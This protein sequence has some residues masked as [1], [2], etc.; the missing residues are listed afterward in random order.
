MPGTS[1]LTR[2][3]P[4]QRRSNASSF[5]AGRFV[6]AMRTRDADAWADF[7]APD[8]EWLEYRHH[9][10][11]RD[12][13][14]RE[15]NVSIH[16]FLKSVCADNRYLHVEDLVAGEESVWFR[17]MV[18]RDDDRMMIEHVH[19]RIENGLIAREIDVE[20]WDYV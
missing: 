10:P 7:F 3:P 13:Q 1:T 12:P 16:E 14:R 8:A 18:R 17:R 11:P 2:E 15:G 19:L 4:Q 5:D 9:N 20:S 6:D